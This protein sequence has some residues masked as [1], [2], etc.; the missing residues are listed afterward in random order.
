MRLYLDANPII[1]SVEGTPSFREAVL[2]WI[3]RV[4]ATADGVILT[5]VLSWL[6]C[7]VKAQR[8]KDEEALKRFDGFF[9][10]ENLTLID[11]STDVVERATDLRVKYGFRTP[12]AIHLAT[13]L[14]SGADVFLTGDRDL[15]RCTEIKVVRLTP[16]TIA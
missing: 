15:D 8:E 6:E 1:Y 3:D 10:R 5:S 14:L 12:D 4:E 2:R 9:V 11:I 16:D 13:A 7:R